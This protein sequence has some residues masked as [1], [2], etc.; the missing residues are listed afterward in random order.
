DR[1][2]HERALAPILVE[3]GIGEE[4]ADDL[5]PGLEP[6]GYVL[7]MHPCT[8]KRPEVREE[9]CVGFPAEEAILARAPGV[10]ID[11]GRRR[12]WH[13]VVASGS[14]DAGGVADKCHAAGGIKVRHV[15]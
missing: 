8:V 15:V 11:I 6:D 13:D 1:L 4:P 10:Q 14:A 7:K 12:W 2:V 5:T 3:R 9:Q